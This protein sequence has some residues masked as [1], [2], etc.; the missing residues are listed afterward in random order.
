[1]YD[2]TQSLNDL[3]GNAQI[4]R[5]GTYANDDPRM[6][7]SAR[8]SRLGMRLKAPEVS[9]VRVTAM[10]EMDLL[11]NQMPVG[12]V[13]AGANG[14]ATVNTGGGNTAT[15]NNPSTAEQPGATGSG[16]STEAQFYTNPTMRVRHANLKVE[17]P[18]V[19]FLFGQYWDLYGWQ[20][21]FAPNSVEIQGLPGQLYSRTPQIRISKSLKNDNV[22]FEAAIAAMR[23]P[24]RDSG[25]PEGQWGV[26]LGTP[27][28]SGLT[29][30]GATGTGI[31]PLSIAVTGD[32]RQ[33]QLPNFTNAGGA[34]TVANQSKVGTSIAVD[35]FLP[36]IPAKERQ[37]NALSVSGEFSTGYGNAD[38]YTGLTGG[39]PATAYTVKGVTT[40]A[41]VDPGMVVYDNLGNLHLIQW[42]SFLI[43]LQYYLPGL[44]GRVWVSG[45]ISQISS[46][47]L[48][49]F[50][51]TA[52]KARD[53]ELWG[54]AN[55]F[56]APTDALRFGAEFALFD[57]VY[58]DGTHAQNIRT[59]FSAFYIF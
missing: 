35:G 39:A 20:Q 57:D 9:G 53:H 32:V 14:S 1:M 15:V 13:A 59:Q 4:A 17:T 10:L 29:T 19:D 47:N 33:F 12:P 23:P 37:G 58:A 44:D 22:I 36:I 8:N 55:L 34:P 52:T 31:Q 3:A 11:G 30:G 16:T 24:Q 54:D 48:K 49:T 46:N 40:Y 6:Q 43:D 21:V 25:V 18:V 27:Q 5:P 7:F 28:W 41:D 45:N 50:Q 42:Q 2:N 51:T 38:L 26:R 56:W